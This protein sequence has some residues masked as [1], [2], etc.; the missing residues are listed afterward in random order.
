MAYH[1]IATAS[2]RSGKFA[3]SFAVRGRCGPFG[4]RVTVSSV[5]SPL[6]TRRRGGSTIAPVARFQSHQ[7][8]PD[9]A[10]AQAV[11]SRC[12]R[13]PAMR[14]PLAGRAVRRCG[15]RRSPDAAAHALSANGRRTGRAGRMDR[16]ARDLRCRGRGLDGA[17]RDPRPRRPSRSDATPSRGAA[18]TGPLRCGSPGWRTTQ[19]RLPQPR[20]SRER[21]LGWTEFRTAR[22]ELRRPPPRGSRPARER[23]GAVSGASGRRGGP[24]SRNRPASCRWRA[25]RSGSPRACWGR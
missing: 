14:R 24:R 8:K 5:R 6:P 25:G 15:G 21:R 18:R 23:R 22:A 9:V 19:H 16:C 2:C 20:G 17:R 12:Q 1:R 13:T 7:P 3:G 10:A 4:A 11:S